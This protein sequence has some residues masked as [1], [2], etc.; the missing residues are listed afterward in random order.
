MTSRQKTKL[1]SIILDR[2]AD[3]LWSTRHEKHRYLKMIFVDG[4]V[5]GSC[6]VEP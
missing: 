1:G 6:L 5:R 4:I 2:C 3:C